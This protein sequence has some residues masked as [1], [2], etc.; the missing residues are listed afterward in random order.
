MSKLVRLYTLNMGS[1]FDYQLYL[2]KAFKKEK[3]SPLE[4]LH[5]CMSYYVTKS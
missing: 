5:V 1:I 3:N 4:R 2:N